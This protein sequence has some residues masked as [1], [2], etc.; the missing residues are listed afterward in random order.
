MRLRLPRRL[1]IIEV[2]GYPESL[3]TQ[4]DEISH[5]MHM[6]RGY[7]IRIARNEEERAKIWLARKSIAGT[8][9]HYTV[10]IT[11]PRSRLTEMLAEVNRICDRLHA[12]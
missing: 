11:V 1:L 8:A 10:D 12:L 2:D 6:Y 5:L 3:D 9:R 7:G 4:M